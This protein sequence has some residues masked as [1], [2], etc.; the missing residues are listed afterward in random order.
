MKKDRLCRR[1]KGLSEKKGSFAERIEGFIL[2]RKGIWLIDRTYWTANI[3][4][5]PIHPP[6][7]SNANIILKENGEI[8]IP[9]PS[10]F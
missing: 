4:P 10:K 8:N 5:R 6:P 1:N 7:D 9:I 2:R 3:P